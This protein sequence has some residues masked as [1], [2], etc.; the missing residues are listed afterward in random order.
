MAF[1]PLAALPQLSATIPLVRL[2]M[3]WYPVPR[4]TSCHC[5]LV[6]PSQV[7]CLSTEPEATLPPLSSTSPVVTFAIRT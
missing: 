7:H 5:R 3:R 6:L 2:T 1:A 4:S